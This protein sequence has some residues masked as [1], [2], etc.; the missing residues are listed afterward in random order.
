METISAKS[1][2]ELAVLLNAIDISVP[3]RGDE[4]KT[5]HVERWSIC[6][7]LA[8]YGHTR[9]VR[10]PL[11]VEKRERPDFCMNSQGVSIGIEITE[12]VSED[13]ARIDAM[14]YDDDEVVCLDVSLFRPGAPRR[15]TQ[16]LREILEASRYSEEGAV[17][18][19]ED[20]DPVARRLMGPGWA[21]E[22]AERDWAEAIHKVFEGKTRS[23]QKPGFVR[24]DETWLLIYD[25]LSL[26]AINVERAADLLLP[27]TES[28]WEQSVLSTC[29][30][31]AGESLCMFAR[32][33][34]RFGR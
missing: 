20:F 29:S 5:A 10:Y 22:G 13:M 31:S 24:F 2:R 27:K 4:R 19:V 7:F 9:F 1:H 6:R 11:I 3:E 15:S 34:R 17:L 18:E 8:T 16:E 23:A 14:R 25:N 32:K 28:L 12:A 26:P 30:S 33:V 21:G